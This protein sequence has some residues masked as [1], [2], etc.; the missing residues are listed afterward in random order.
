[1]ITQLVDK[2]F[3]KGKCKQCGF[4]LRLPPKFSIKGD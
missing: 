4:E 1:M 2:T 3:S